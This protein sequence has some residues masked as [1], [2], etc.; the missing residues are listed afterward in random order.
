MQTEKDGAVEVEIKQNAEECQTC[1]SSYDGGN[2]KN[3]D[4]PHVSLACIQ[5]SS[6]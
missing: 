1:G 2:C 4:S 5:L 3:C 6:K